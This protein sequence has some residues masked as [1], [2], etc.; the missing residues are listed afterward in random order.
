[1][2]MACLEKEMEVLLNVVDVY[3]KE[4]QYNIHLEKSVLIKQN[5]N[6]S[7]KHHVDR[8]TAQIV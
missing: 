3:L 5:E 2:Q 7:Q 8:F 6:S 4:Y 1:M